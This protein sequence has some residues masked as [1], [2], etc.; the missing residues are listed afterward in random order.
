MILRNKV[1]ERPKAGL[2]GQDCVGNELELLWEL[3][4]NQYWLDQD[5]QREEQ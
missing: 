2:L 3:Q 1:I 5:E 4:E